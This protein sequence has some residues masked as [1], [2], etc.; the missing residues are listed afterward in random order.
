MNKLTTVYLIRHSTKFNVRED[1]ESYNT[2]DNK[3]IKT[4]KNMLTIEGEK[5]AEIL[6]KETEMQ[7]LDKVYCSNYARAMQT[8]KYLIHENNLKLNIDDRFNE[9]RIGYPDKEKHPDFFVLQYWNKDFRNLEG[10]AQ[11]E[12]NKRMTEAFWEV[13]NNNKGKRIAIVSHGTSISFLLM[14]W[15]KLIDVQQNL[16]RCFEFNGKQIINRKYYSPEVFKVVVND[17]DEII[18]VSNVVFESLIED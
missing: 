14:N 8:A 9:R 6:S 18:D 2:T 10:E 5:R 11:V 16:L 12:V 17:K 3:Q 7:N 15:C 4:E 13:V 1:I